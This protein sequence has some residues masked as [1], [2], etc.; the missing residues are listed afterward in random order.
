[1]SPFGNFSDRFLKGLAGEAISG[2]FTTPGVAIRRGWNCGTVISEMRGG[3]TAMPRRGREMSKTVAKQRELARSVDQSERQA[4][5]GSRAFAQFSGLRCVGLG[6]RRSRVQISAARPIKPQ[7]E[8]HFRRSAFWC[9]E[10]HVTS[11]VTFFVSDG[12]KN[13]FPTAFMAADCV[14][15]SRWA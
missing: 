11:D 2:G 14:P 4:R 8:A 1:M 5:G 12:P 3:T 7:V 9:V 15:G 13:S 6:D 10:P